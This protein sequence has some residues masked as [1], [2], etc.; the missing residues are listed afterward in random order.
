MEYGLYRKLTLLPLILS[1]WLAFEAVNKTSLAVTVPVNA[2]GNEL[3][4]N[5]RH[6]HE[7][8]LNPRKS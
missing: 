3:S 6:K 7:S 2:D 1:R 5:C 4:P 8:N